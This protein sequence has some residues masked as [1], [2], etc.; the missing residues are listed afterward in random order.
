MKNCRKLPDGRVTGEVKEA[1]AAYKE[2]E[3]LTGYQYCFVNKCRT[4]GHHLR[5][6]QVSDKDLK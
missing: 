3:I 1:I 5:V 2:G 4:C 6:K